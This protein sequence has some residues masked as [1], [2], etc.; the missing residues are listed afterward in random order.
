MRF[1]GNGLGLSVLVALAMVL[2]FGSAPAGA[3]SLAD[4]V[5]GMGFASTDGSLTFDEFDAVVTGNLSPDLSNYELV[6]VDQGF[7]LVGPVGVADGEIG[8]ILLSYSVVTAD[9]LVIAGASLYANVRAIG[10]GSQANVAE[11]LFGAG[12]DPIASL[13][14]FATGGGGF[15]PTDAAAFEPVASLRMVVKDIQV[16][17]AGPAGIA[18]ISIVEQTFA[19][20]PEPATVLLVALGAGGLLVAGRRRQR[21]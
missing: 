18:A 2:G 9:S 4:A 8:D 1:R 10:S 15:D 11:D 20:V 12:Q 21:V 19:V 16:K 13:F 3:L 17:S 7:R 5:G 14:V 6:A